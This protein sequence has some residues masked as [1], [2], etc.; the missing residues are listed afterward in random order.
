[1]VQP[2][3]S[4]LSG[5][6]SL[7]LGRPYFLYISSLLMVSECLTLTAPFPCSALVLSSMRTA[8]SIVARSQNLLGGQIT[9]LTSPIANFRLMGPKEVIESC[10]LASSFS[11]SI[12]MCSLGIYMNPLSSTRRTHSP[13]TPI[14]LLGMTLVP[15]P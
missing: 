2:G 4:E 12:Q 14:T 3:I 10:T 15:F 6:L 9:R 13:A 5:S 11:H 7:Y 1:M 8:S